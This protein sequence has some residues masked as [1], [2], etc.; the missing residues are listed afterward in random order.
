VAAASCKDAA[1]VP[2]LA[3][4]AAGTLAGPAT[5]AA[6]GPQPSRRRIA[7]A[8]GLAGLVALA[9]L[10]LDR[11]RL[12]SLDAAR[13]ATPLPASPP[14]D[15]GLPIPGISPLYTP[16]GSFYV[17]DVTARPPRLDANEWR[18]R[19]GGMVDRTLELTLDD[20]TSLGLVELDATLVCVHNPVGG[21]RIGTA[22]WLGVPIATLLE[23]AG[24]QPGAE[25][26]LARSVD[27]F[28]AG[29][30]VE[31]IRSGAPAL[32][33]IGMNGEPLPFDHGFPAR[34]LVPG[35]WGADANTK[36]LTELELTTWG[37]VSD[38]WDRRGWPRQ[39]SRVQPA[40]RIDVPAARA[41]VAPGAVTVAGVAWAPPLG[42][43]GVEVQVDDGP[44]QPADLGTEVAPTMWRQWS[45]TWAATTGEHV[46]RARTIGRDRTQP[47]GAEPPYPVGVRGY[48]ERRVSVVEGGSGSRRLAALVDDARERLVLAGRGATAWRDR[49]FPP[50][51]SFPAPLPGRSP[52]RGK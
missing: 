42:V 34:L 38:Y 1:P 4:G 23:R 24:V 47:G 6:L 27:G 49:G 35:L 3:A 5:L 11:A 51:P 41:V 48:H 2:T 16:A 44:W 52:H 25:Q 22:R 7:A 31:R 10:A 36:W 32:L 19:V 45:W 21:D 9:A 20:L 14:P 8:A 29:V 40:A 30:P 50:T 43:E 39:P 28:T 26:L 33:A 37:A 13:A 17:T 18:L 12:R 15:R 46:L